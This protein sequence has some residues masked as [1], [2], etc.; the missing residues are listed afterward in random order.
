MFIKINEER[1]RISTIKRYKKQVVTTGNSLLIWFTGDNMFTAFKFEDVSK[2]DAMI[3]YL[4][5]NLQVK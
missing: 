2:L 1:F 4:D 3:V 5:K